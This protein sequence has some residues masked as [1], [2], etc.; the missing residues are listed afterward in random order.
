M[1]KEIEESQKI[2]IFELIEELIDVYK[3]DNWLIIKKYIVRYS[4]PDIRKYFSTRHHYTKKHSLNN[5]ENDLIKICKEKYNRTFV[6]YE[7]DKHNE[8]V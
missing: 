5:F 1:F 8:I 3:D 4:H 2:I 6:L 7:E